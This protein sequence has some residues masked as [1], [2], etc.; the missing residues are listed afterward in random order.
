MIA[1]F[2][3]RT[4]KTKKYYFIFESKPSTLFFCSENDSTISEYLKKNNT[5]IILP[6]NVSKNSL[7]GLRY[8]GVVENNSRNFNTSKTFGKK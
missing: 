7:C 4:G 6:L 8:R 2:K 3:T 1:L 5:I